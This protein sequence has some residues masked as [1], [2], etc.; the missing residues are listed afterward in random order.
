MDSRVKSTKRLMLL[1]KQQRSNR[2][3]LQALEIVEETPNI[4]EEA[5][6]GA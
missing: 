5:G 2:E 1:K 3:Q 4:T 6:S